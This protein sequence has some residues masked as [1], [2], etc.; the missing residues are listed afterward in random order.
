M[1]RIKDVFEFFQCRNPL[2]V[3]AVDHLGPWS[4]WPAEKSAAFQEDFGGIQKKKLPVVLSPFFPRMGRGTGQIELA[5]ASAALD[6]WK[7][8]ASD[9]TIRMAMTQS[10]LL[11]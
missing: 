9:V 8:S 3:S 10:C 6:H 11:H 1:I 4:V 2:W 7:N 5:V